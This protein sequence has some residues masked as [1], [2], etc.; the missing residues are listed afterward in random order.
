MEDIIFH[1][2]KFEI[3]GIQIPE[4]KLYSGSLIKIYIPNFNHEKLPLGFDLTTELIKKFQNQKTDLPWAKRY[5]QNS[6]SEFFNPITVNKYL[7]NKI[8]IDKESAKRIIEELSLNPNE[9][10]NNLSYK[11]TKILAIKALFE[12]NNSIILDYYGISANGIESLE[13]IVNTEIIKGKSGIVFDNL[14]FAHEKEP[15]ENI[16]VMKI[17]SDQQ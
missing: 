8:K 3:N 9:K 14:Q 12:K 6:I 5:L 17:N 1:S 10:Y 15:F 16:K 11:K 2:K 4:F 7:I 13:A